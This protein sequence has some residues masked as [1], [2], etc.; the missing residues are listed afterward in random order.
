MSTGTRANEPD[1]AD[2]RQPFPFRERVGETGFTTI[3][4]RSPLREAVV[5][6]AVQERKGNNMVRAG[7]RIAGFLCVL[8]LAG[9][10]CSVDETG[11]RVVSL[12]FPAQEDQ[13]GAGLS[14]NSTKVQEAINFID[15]ELAS[16]GFVRKTNET[17]RVKGVIA[18]Y[19]EYLDHTT[20]LPIPGPAVGWGRGRLVV[21]FPPL[22]GNPLS[23]RS[24]ATEKSL[25]RALT[26]RYGADR[27][28]IER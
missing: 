24:E 11:A 26:L 23:P 1:G 2:R 19:V 3:D 13:S 17:S 25:R 15:T 27:V 16:S 22:P 9:A 28:K 6:E 4:R 12:S 5:H 7:L 20:T 18:D 8:L 10:G 14:V 21:V